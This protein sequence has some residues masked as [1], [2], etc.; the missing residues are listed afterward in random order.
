[1]LSLTGQVG[2]I[3]IVTINLYIYCNNKSIPYTISP[4]TLH[5]EN[6]VN[7]SFLFI[8]YVLRNIHVLSQTLMCC[9]P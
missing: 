1:M 9:C 8:F 6:F 4:K 5:F 7:G 2:Q 3:F